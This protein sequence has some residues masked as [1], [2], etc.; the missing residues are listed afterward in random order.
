VHSAPAGVVALDAEVSN[1]THAISSR[2]RSRIAF[3]DV[4][5]EQ[6]LVSAAVGLQVRGLVPFVSRS[7]L[8]LGPTTSSDA[9]TPGPTSGW[10]DPTRERDRR[11]RT[12]QMALEDLA[13]FGPSRVDVLYPS[14]AVST[15]KLVADDGRPHRDR[16]PADHPQRLSRDLRQRRALPIAAPRWCAA[17]TRTR[18]R[19]SRPGSRCTAPWPPPTSWRR[20]VSTSGSSTATR[21][22]IAADVL[23]EAA[24]TA[25]TWWSWRHYPEGGLGAAVMEALAGDHPLGSSIWQSATSREAAR[26]PICSPRRDRRRRDRQGGPPRPPPAQEAM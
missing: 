23:A 2:R 26:P 8:L 9:A 4:H 15:V 18:L 3:R 11:R 24:A 19:W 12:L 17:A 1:S 5:R 22:A 16:L 21:Q 6:Q 20:R 14:D 10:S 25:G 7:R 13:S